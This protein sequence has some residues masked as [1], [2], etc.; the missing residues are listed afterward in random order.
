MQTHDTAD[1]ITKLNKI[2][3]NSPKNPLLRSALN[4][5]ETFN[6]EKENY[7]AV[8]LGRWGTK[9]KELR[10]PV[11]WYAINHASAFVETGIANRFEID[12][13]NGSH[14]QRHLFDVKMSFLHVHPRLNIF[15]WEWI[16]QKEKEGNVVYNGKYVK[17]ICLRADL[18]IEEECFRVVI[19]PKHGIG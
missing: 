1:E 6:N 8:G 17:H 7:I 14:F 10:I 4:R 16:E 2:L 11:G 12:P 5:I 15:N 18:T 9:S 3:F 19:E 13:S